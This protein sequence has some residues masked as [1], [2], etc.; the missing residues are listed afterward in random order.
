MIISLVRNQVTPL[1][2]IKYTNT[3]W[4]SR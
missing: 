3:G 4:G 1:T 2:R